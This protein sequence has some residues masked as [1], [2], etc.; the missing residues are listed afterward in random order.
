MFPRIPDGLEYSRQCVDLS[1]WGV[2]TTREWKAGECIGDYE[3]ERMLKSEFI[4]RYGK[5]IRY[6]YYTR[7]NFSNSTVIVAKDPKNFIGYIN[8]NKTQP[9]VELKQYK[10]W[11]KRDIMIGE[12]LL[13]KYD[14]RDYPKYL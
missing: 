5:D 11:C 12:E 2:L 8:E 14:S 3:G 6:T 1:G 13:L 9:N 7:H 4:K 10:L